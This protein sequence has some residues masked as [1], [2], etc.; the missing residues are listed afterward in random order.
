MIA[1]S[2]ELRTAR[3]VAVLF[4]LVVLL[5]RF[6]VPGVPNVA[7]LVPVVVVWAALALARRIAVVD[8]TRLLW[9]FAAATTSCFVMLIQ[10]F[11][12]AGAEISVTAWGLVMVVWLPFV[13]RLVE[14]GP[15]AYLQTLRY[16]SLIAT[17]L[18][19]L[20]IAMVGTQLLGIPHRDWFAVLVPE[21]LQ[22]GGFVLTY[23]L[24]YGSNILRGNAWIGLEPSMVSAQLG[25]GLLA[26]LFVRA[27]WWTVVVLILG[28][29][30]TASGSGIVIVIIGVLVMMLHRC[31][32]LLTKYAV[33]GGVTVVLATLTPFGS[34]LLD[35]SSEFSSSGS[36]ASLRAF[37][38]Y[39][40]LFPRW[41]EQLSGVLWGYG[42]GSS[43][44]IVTDTNVLGLLVPSPA[45]VFFEYGLVAG[46][47]LAAFLLGCYWGGPSRTMGLSLLVS[48]WLLQPGVT[49]MVIVAP[50]LA[51]VTLWSPRP[52]PPIEKLLPFPATNQSK[53]SMRNLVA[54]SSL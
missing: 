23:P 47:V 30:A 34:L 29:V 54:T 15:A 18:A 6:A 8:R 12:V 32:Q 50:L 11:A 14:N 45:K 48:L 20:T 5:Q 7:L 21:N 25:I 26:A 39:G 41:T 27:R 4:L 44:R 16:V 1:S 36:S 17:I 28:L 3:W 37:E 38:P 9:W 24:N 51:M 42:P 46:V 52:G 35:R 33:L 19:I 53:T 22:L 40:V 49:T 43:Q 10:D 13:L 2:V 31:R